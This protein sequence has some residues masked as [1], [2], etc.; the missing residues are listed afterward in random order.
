MKNN[1]NHLTK[2]L[3]DHYGGNPWIDVTI[4]GELKKLTAIQ[5]AAK[6]V[7]LNSVW[8]IVNHMIS[9]R[10]ALISRVMG[11]Q[12]KYSND[13]FYR[14]VKDKSPAAWRKTIANLKKSQKEI[15]SFL[16]KQDD[17]L[18]ETVS[19]TSGY[20]YFELVEAILIHDAYHT[21]QIVLVKKLLQ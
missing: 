21:G 16:K 8:E 10:K 13:N 9:W 20:T 15:I 6:P 17:E 5:A 1:I 3:N 2:L 7:G 11:R 14:E 18:L 4:T 12:V 19:P